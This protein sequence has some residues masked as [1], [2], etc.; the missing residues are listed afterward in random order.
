MP[1]PRQTAPTDYKALVCIFLFGGND[2]VEHDRAASTPRSY[3]AYEMGRR[4]A[5]AAGTSL[6]LPQ[7]SL[8]QLNATT[9]SANLSLSGR[10]HLDACR[11]D[12]FEGPV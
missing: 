7:A 12:G 11:N 1:R 3:A 10:S 9:P 2:H 5:G 4:Q 8:L 6:A